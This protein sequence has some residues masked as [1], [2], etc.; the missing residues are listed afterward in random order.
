[1]AF[2]DDEI[3]YASLADRRRAIFARVVGRLAA[4]GMPIDS[5]PRFLQLADQ[6][7]N[8]KIE[9][10]DVARGYAEIRRAARDLPVPVPDPAKPEIMADRVSQEKLLAELEHIIGVHDPDASS[11][12]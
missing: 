1:M 4:R 9:M 2:S 6:W 11:S 7:I 3:A 5:D 12:K 8:G 10:E